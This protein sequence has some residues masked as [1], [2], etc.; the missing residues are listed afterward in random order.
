MTPVQH[1]APTR[2]AAKVAHELSRRLLQGTEDVGMAGLP[3]VLVL[4][5]CPAGHQ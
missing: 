5:L 4:A 2:Q 1:P 3:A